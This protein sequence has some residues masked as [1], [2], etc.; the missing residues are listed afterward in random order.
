MLGTAPIYNMETT[1]EDETARLAFVV[2]IVNVP[3]IIPI[4]VR[5]ESDY[6]L[7]MVVNTI[8]QTIALTSA[9]MTI[10]GFPAGRRP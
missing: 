7:R 2:P 1:G 10:W 8:S 5:S 4:Q 6:G 9:S 3:V